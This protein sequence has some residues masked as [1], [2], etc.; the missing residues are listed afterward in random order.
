MWSKPLISLLTVD[1]NI[2]GCF[3]LLKK[4]VPK[5]GIYLKKKVKSERS[6]DAFK[7]IKM[8]NEKWERSRVFYL[9]KKLA[10]TRK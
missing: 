10:I 7:G 8:K 2:P 1:C 4:A 6:K 3:S 5:S 9:Q